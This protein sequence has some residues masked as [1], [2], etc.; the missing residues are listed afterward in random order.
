MK[1]PPF[2]LANVVAVVGA[3]VTAT[4]VNRLIVKD[5]G[6]GLQQIQVYVCRE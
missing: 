4:M 1:A 6:A 3:T 5:R 2:K